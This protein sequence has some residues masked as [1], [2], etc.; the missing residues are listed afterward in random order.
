[1]TPWGASLAFPQ[2][3]LLQSIAHDR[4][5]LPFSASGGTLIPIF[6]VQPLICGIILQEQV[7]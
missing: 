6:I 4:N 3:K 7:G 1:M 5:I 2:M